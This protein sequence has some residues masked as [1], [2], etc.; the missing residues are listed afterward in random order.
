VRWWQIRKRDA[1]L[2]RELRSDL[3]LEEEELRED[4]LPPEE[5]RHAALRAFGN[6]TLIREQTREIWS[7]NGLESFARDLRFG[8]RT[9]RRAPGFTIIAVVVM[10]LGIGANIALFTVVRGVLLKPLPF[11]NPDRLVSLYQRQKELGQFVPIDG[12][13]FT[14]WQQATR[15]SAEMAIVNS[16][17]QYNVSS[18][19]G[20]LPERVET[21][22]TSWNFFSLLGVTPALGRGFTATDDGPSTEATVI[23]SNGFWKRRYSSDP[24]VVGSKI[25]L[26]AT[27]YTVIGVLPAWFK[28]EGAFVEGKTQLWTT[29]GHEAGP[30]LLHSFDEHAFV[31]VA[32]L[33]PRSTL[34]SLLGQLDAVQK[35]IKREH[36]G[37]VVSDT[38]NGRSLLDDEVWAFKTPFM[39]SWRPQV[40]YY[41]SLA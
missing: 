5:A 10:A 32:R 41:S 25:W 26:N 18:E 12:G 7:W 24:K 22:W 6:P 8:L 20:Q 40:V 15:D 36:P 33:L 38:V 30:E 21:A 1:E 27:P 13:S 34:S 17:Q 16:W 2:E 11:R 29:V 14:R 37:A 31:V 28:Y 3:E 9:L 4:G 23:L 35:E 39:R 19:E